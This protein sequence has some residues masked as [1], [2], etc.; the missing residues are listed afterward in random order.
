MRP[1]KSYS[2]AKSVFVIL[3]TLLL[4]SVIVPTLAQARKFKV[5][6]TFHGG[7]GAGPIGQ[8]VRDQA[9]N[10]YGT[11]AIGGTGKCQGGC[12]TA[13]KMNKFG[14][15]IWVHSFN[16][17]NGRQPA[18]G[19]LRDKAGN[20]Y[21]TTGLGGRINNQICSLGCG[22]VFRLDKTGKETVLHK[23]T[24]TPDGYFPAGAPLVEDGAGNVYGA[25]GVGGAN[26]VGAVFKLDQAGKETVPYSFSGGSDGCDPSAGVILD[27]AGNLYGVTLDGGGGF[28]NSGFG[29]AFE[30][31][32][33]GDETVLHAFGGSDGANPDSVL[34]FDS[35]GNLY[36]T[37]Q[38]GGSSTVCG[39][40]CG[41][42]FELSPDNGS[43]S[44]TVLYS[45]CLLSNCID[46]ETPGPGPLVRDAAGNLYGAT[47]FGGTY[48]NCNRDACGVVFKLDTTGKETVLHSFT[49]GTDGAGPW[50]L[51]ADSAGNL[52]GSALRGGDRSC[53]VGNGQ[54]CGVVFRVAP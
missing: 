23:F 47:D 28:C 26:G 29:V 35:Q 48:R 21:G 34:L 11:T 32:T 25:T 42:V 30:V 15:M 13:F 17:A 37:T 3:I 4:T 10:L 18:A 49:G 14:K 41:T 22:V 50:G 2:G 40:G 53:K 27:A 5:L 31:N 46:G 54:G 19:L 36:G 6:H 7:D 9:G 52:Y 1:T 39:G 43:W 38:N 20:L 51:A 12:G 8:L 45:F 24:G 44:E 16:G 33:S